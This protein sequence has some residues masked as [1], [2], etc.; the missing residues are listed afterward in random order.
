MI[1]FEKVLLQLRK[2]L[3]ILYKVFKTFIFK[4][5]IVICP[6][7]TFQYIIYSYFSL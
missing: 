7:V 3:Y 1:L 2:I 4:F 5:I 6:H